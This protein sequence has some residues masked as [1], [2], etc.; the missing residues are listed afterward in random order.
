MV[1]TG[2][3]EHVEQH[4]AQRRESFPMQR[5][6]IKQAASYQKNMSVPHPCACVPLDGVETCAQNNGE[7]WPLVLCL[8]NGNDDWLLLIVLPSH[9]DLTLL[10]VAVPFIIPL[11][12]FDGVDAVPSKPL[13]PYTTP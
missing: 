3:S 6:W 1:K 12:L 2:D 11:T 10:T 13:T 8:D 4:G 9:S 5:Q 7:H